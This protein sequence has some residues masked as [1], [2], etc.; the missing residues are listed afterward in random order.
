[1][2]RATRH[3]AALLRELAA[4][5]SHAGTRVI[6]TGVE[7]TPEIDALCDAAAAAVDAALPYS[8]VHEG[9]TWYVQ[10][11][12]AAR[13]HAFADRAKSNR[14]GDFNLQTSVVVRLRFT[15]A[16]S[17]PRSPVEFLQG[18]QA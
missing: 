6:T 4:L 11:A 5:P 1:M 10:A 16:P 8:F 9:Q 7:G 13:L 2:G 3:H 14:L 12:V 15:D 18:G 17:E